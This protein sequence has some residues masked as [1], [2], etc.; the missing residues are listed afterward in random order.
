M[1]SNTDSSACGLQPTQDPHL[2]NEGKPFRFLDLPAEVRIMVYRKSVRDHNDFKT[3]CSYPVSIVSVRR[4]PITELRRVSNTFKGEYDEE[5]SR[6][7]Q[8]H[9]EIEISVPNV[10]LSSAIPDIFQLSTPGWR[11]LE[12]V[13]LPDNLSFAHIRD[14][15]VVLKRPQLG[16]GKMLAE[17]STGAQASETQRKSIKPG[18]L[19][20][21]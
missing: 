5:V 19:I 13:L 4:A 10:F 8:L 21:R 11:G 17:R 7:M 14:A 16:P 6:T 3:Q 12:D 9:L 1:D 20:L 15:I 2:Y 18:I